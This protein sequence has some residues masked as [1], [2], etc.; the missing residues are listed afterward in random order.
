MQNPIVKPDGPDL[1]TTMRPRG[2]TDLHNTIKSSHR[3]LIVGMGIVL[4]ASALNFILGIAG[5][6]LTKE[7]KVD[8]GVVVDPDGNIL[9]TGQ[10]VMGYDF[11]D[12]MMMN[13]TT[14]V[15][16][17]LS[18]LDKFSISVDDYVTTGYRVNSWYVN[19]GL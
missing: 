14:D 9:H 10:S 18:N 13:D 16:D 5:N 17:Y 7:I 8:S 6:E 15:K 12:L 4:F 11:T 1:E 2:L 19:D 3:K